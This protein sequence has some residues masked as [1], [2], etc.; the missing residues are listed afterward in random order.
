MLNFEELPEYETTDDEEE[1]QQPEPMTPSRHEN[2]GLNSPKA[3]AQMVPYNQGTPNMK[4]T[5]GKAH[6][7]Q[8]AKKPM[9]Q[10]DYQ[11]S[12]QYIEQFYQNQSREGQSNSNQTGAADPDGYDDLP[13]SVT[14]ESSLF[15]EKGR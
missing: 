10:K 3:V 7:Q 6:L 13:K 12:Y 9:N 2:L 11:K 15:V 5:Q 1:E 14:E 8:A 4:E